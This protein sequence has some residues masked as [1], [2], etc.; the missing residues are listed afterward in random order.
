MEGCTES[1]VL[2]EIVL[3][4][5][6][7]SKKKKKN[8]LAAIL[9]GRLKMFPVPKD[10]PRHCPLK[11][12]FPDPTPPKPNTSKSKLV[13]SNVGKAGEA[14][15]TLRL[16]RWEIPKCWTEEGGEMRPWGRPA[17]LAQCKDRDPGH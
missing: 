11:P 12:L 13:Q 5:K 16:R 10:I 3:L 2:R 9:E 4:I 7:P 8:H 17:P 1:L 15:V 6:F 14:T